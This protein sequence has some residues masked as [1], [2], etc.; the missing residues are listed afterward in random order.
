MQIGV[1]KVSSFPRQEGGQNLE[2]HILLVPVAVGA[3][4]NHANLV[5][6]AFDE[7]ELDL[8]AGHAIRRDARPVP[9]DQGGKFLK[10]PKP[11]P[12]ELLLPAGEELARPPSRR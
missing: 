4:L 2:S 1:G 8:V 11:L 7:A 6:Q 3:P 9:F 12:L 5:I 10:R